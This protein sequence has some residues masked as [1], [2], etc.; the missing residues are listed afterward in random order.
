[1]IYCVL[2]DYLSWQPNLLLID[3]LSINRYI[4]STEA[5]LEGHTGKDISFD[6]RL[7][8]ECIFLAVGTPERSLHSPETGGGSSHTGDTPFPLGPHL[9]VC[10]SWKVQ[11]NDSEFGQHQLTPVVTSWLDRTYRYL[12]SSE[13]TGWRRSNGW[14]NSLLLAKL[15]QRE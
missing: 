3:F 15:L 14:S 2:A 11:F 9:Q 8:I 6:G 12:T 5:N 1:M 4:F 13:L 7:Y 10:M